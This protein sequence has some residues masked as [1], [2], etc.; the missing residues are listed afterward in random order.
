MGTPNQRSRY[1]A[2]QKRN[3]K[4]IDKIKNPKSRIDHLQN[5]IRD[6]QKMQ[7]QIGIQYTHIRNSLFSMK[8]S[9]DEL[10]KM[11]KEDKKN[12]S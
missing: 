10:I 12:D 9:I 2:K 11:E 3:K 7:S 5:I 8:D 1:K 6:F 4:Y